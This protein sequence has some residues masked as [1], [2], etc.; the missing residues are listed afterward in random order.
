MG[1]VQIRSI[2][3][4]YILSAYVHPENPMTSGKHEEWYCI[5]IQ[6]IQSKLA[7]YI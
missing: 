5:D 3:N 7:K 2:E 4:G 1:N 6:E